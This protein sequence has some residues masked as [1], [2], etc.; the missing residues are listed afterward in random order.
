VASYEDS[1][2]GVKNGNGKPSAARWF[3][4]YRAFVDVWMRIVTPMETLVMNSLFR[5]ANNEDGETFVT[6]ETIAEETGCDVRRVQ[7]TLA[8]LQR[9]EGD[10]GP[11]GNLPPGRGIV[12][13]ITDGGR[14]RG[15]IGLGAV[16]R[17]RTDKTP[18]SHATL[19][20]PETPAS[21]DYKPRHPETLNPGI[22]A[23]LTPAP[24]ATPTPCNS[25][26]NSPITTTTGAANAAVVVVVERLKKVGMKRVEIDT[27]FAD[28][29]NTVAFLTDCLDVLDFKREI[30]RAR[31][32]L[33]LLRSFIKNGVDKTEML[34]YREL[35]AAEKN[36]EAEEAEEAKKQE[37]EKERAAREQRDADDYV[38]SLTPT[39]REK[40]GNVI[41]LAINS[42]YIEAQPLMKDTN[43]IGLMKLRA[44]GITSDSKR[45][46]IAI[47]MAEIQKRRG[48]AA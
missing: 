3:V 30:G 16:R 34:N 10:R 24:G 33:R 32:P 9:I 37:E 39:E 41:N 26:I 4:L 19:Y 17:I 5:H 47:A 22:S 36:R 7:R 21:D 15:A 2:R 11:A 8:T 46:E 38:K 43:R 45:P 23:P 20:T 25:L 1:H 6:P 31:Y 12:E 35:Q 40:W 48:T 29:E 44:L 13:K 18:A 27:H 14:G 42:E 28:P